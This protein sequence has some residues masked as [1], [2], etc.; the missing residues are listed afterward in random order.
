MNDQIDL[1]PLKSKALKIGGP[2]RDVV[3]SQPDI[4]SREDYLAKA[5]DWLRL[6]QIAEETSQK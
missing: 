6:L 4:I 2:F 5:G 3:V 1:R